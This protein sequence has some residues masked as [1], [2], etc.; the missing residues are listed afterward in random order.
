M[1][2]RK[3]QTTAISSN[4]PKKSKLRMP[5]ERNFAQVCIISI[6]V[7]CTLFSF[8][9]LF[10][11]VVNSLKTEAQVKVNAFSLPE[12]ATMFSAAKSNFSI[13][14]SA[15]GS[16]YFT[17]MIVSLVG[18][19]G[20]VVISVALAYILTFKNFY[21]KEAVF[22]LFIAVLLVPSIIGYPILVPL[23]RDTL[24]MGDSYL[25][26]LLPMVGGGQVVGMFLFRTFFSQQPKSLYESAQLDGANDFTML[27]RIT[28]PLAMPIIL[29]HFV[30]SFAGIYNEYLWASLIL[31]KNQTLTNIMYAVVEN[32]TVK[33]GAMYAMYLISSL[34]LIVTAI[35][36]M[37]Y[38]KSGEFAA[39]LK[40]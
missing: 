25:G 5:Y 16:Y 15:I 17:T 9:P 21:F 2:T 31:E 38:F 39:G 22:M 19:V 11:T 40:L 14:W 1:D 36:S 13:A 33:Y 12:L 6:V 3:E 24:H 30:G 28:L 23:V 26:Y 27:T 4:N 32:N 35:I 18:A 7:F 20:K 10:L 34:P 8:L 29:Y 37:K